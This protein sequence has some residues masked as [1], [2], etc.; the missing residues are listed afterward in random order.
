LGSAYV[1]V[2]SATDHEQPDDEDDKEE[3]QQEAQDTSP[4]A[5]KAKNL[6][7]KK[8]NGWTDYSPGDD[9]GNPASIC[10]V[11]LSAFLVRTLRKLCNVLGILGVKKTKKEA[12][13]LLIQQEYAKQM[14]YASIGLVPDPTISFPTR[15]RLGTKHRMYASVRTYGYEDTMRVRLVVERKNERNTTIIGRDMGVGSVETRVNS[16]YRSRFHVE[17]AH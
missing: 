5:V 16:C 3:Q 1:G 10:G 12:I 15:I 7:L 9:E 14:A 6:D 4:D 8:V 17:R 11:P 13:I 2:R